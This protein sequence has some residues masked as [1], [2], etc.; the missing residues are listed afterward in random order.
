[1]DAAIVV[2]S[3]ETGA[4]AQCK[5]LRAL[6]VGDHVMVEVDGIRTVRQAKEREIRSTKQEFTFMGVDVSSK[7]QVELL[8]EQ[9]A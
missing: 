4:I 9:I 3:I 2:Q 1:M 8:V 5:L 7:R 6:K